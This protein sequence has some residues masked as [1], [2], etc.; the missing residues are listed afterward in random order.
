MIRTPVCDL[1]GIEFPI[2]QGGMAWLATA[3]LAAAVSQGGGLGVIGGGDCPPDYVRQQVQLAKSL[4]NKP[5]GV[6][7]PLF[8]PH[9]KDVFGVCIEEGVKVIFTGAGNPAPHVP[10]L[11]QAGVIVI[12]VV[13]SVA[14]AK[15]LERSGVDAIVA[16][17]MESGGHVGDVSTLPLVPQ[18]VDALKIPVIAAGGIADG[19]GLVAALALGAQAIQM[20]TRFVCVDEC[21]AHINYKQRIVAA[22]DRATITTGHSLGHPVRAIRNRM[23]H[24]FAELERRGC[25]EEEVIAFG[26]GR[27]RRACMEGD[28]ETGSVMS[29]Q[30]CGLIHDI[31][32]AAE[33]IRRIMDE[34]EG[35]LQRLGQYLVPS[36][37]P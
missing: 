32:P 17:G 37:A 18:V 8:S 27:L 25:T 11:K 14:L 13:A 29:G 2:V 34:A 12:P 36:P 6:N 3:E 26:T 9:I 1:L 28:V 31:A 24:D 35:C 23:T 15:R 4:T 19:R 30:S 33:V 10:R 5:F 21:V 7:V 16:E 20:G 22:G